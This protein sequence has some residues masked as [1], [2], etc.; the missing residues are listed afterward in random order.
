MER[1][2]RER[3]GKGKGKGKGAQNEG[4][5]V[6]GGIGKRWKERFI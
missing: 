5:E 6:K 1:K 4:G 3:K 2:R